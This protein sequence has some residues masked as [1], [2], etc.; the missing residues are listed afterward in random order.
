MP[1]VKEIAK[2]IEDFAPRHLQEDFDNAGLQ[3]GDPDMEVKEVLVCLDVT[4]EILDEAI[5][6]QCNLI[7]T[8]H[9][10]I[11]GGIKEITGRNL[12]QKI[13]IKAIKNDIAIYSAHTNLDNVW[14]GVS[15]Q[16]AHELRLSNITTLERRHPYPGS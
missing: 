7:V 5:A 3:V 16:M 10:L 1:T 4:E 2:A 8:H 13:V 12:T 6:K 14:D 11:Y 9:P 15:H